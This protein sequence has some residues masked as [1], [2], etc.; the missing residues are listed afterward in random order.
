MA[1]RRQMRPITTRRRPVKSGT[2]QRIHIPQIE[3]RPISLHKRDLVL[4]EEFQ[5][6][7]WWFVIHRRGIRRPRVGEDPLE[8]RAVSHDTVRGTL[9]ERIMYMAFVNL[10]HFSPDYDFDFQSSQQ[11]GRLELGGLVADFILPYLKIVVRVQGPTHTEWLR[12][13]K[14][15]EQRMILEEMGFL[16]LD[17][18]DTLIYDEYRFEEWLRR[19]F[20]LGGRGGSSPAHG[21]HKADE[22]E[23]QNAVWLEMVWSQV[24]AAEQKL[25]DLFVLLPHIL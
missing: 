13:R 1:K 15:E 25:D 24:Q 5:G 6:S 16:V 2:E 17:A 10:L 3:P 20:L 23:Q 21:A 8:A 7:P 14:D 18:E 12:M 9:P 22:Q 19:N 4:R 11:G